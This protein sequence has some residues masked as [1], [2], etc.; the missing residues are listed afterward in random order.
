MMVRNE[1]WLDNL[2]L[3]T[4]FKNAPLGVMRDD[5]FISLAAVPLL[6]GTRGGNATRYMTR[7]TFQGDDAGPTVGVFADEK[8]Y[9][10]GAPAIQIPALLMLFRIATRFN[11]AKGGPHESNKCACIAH[12]GTKNAAGAFF[13]SRCA[14]TCA[15]RTPLTARAFI[16]LRMACMQTVSSCT[17]EA[18]TPEDVH[19]ALLLLTSAPH[20]FRSSHAP[21]R[22]VSKL[23]VQDTSWH[24]TVCTDLGS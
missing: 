8:S 10:E 1:M 4:L 7:M 9:V 11:S 3:R 19:S 13:A 24:T 17:L 21:S 12:I 6:N 22:P 16:A 14:F 5:Q 18:L 2:Y 15:L 20:T 23:L